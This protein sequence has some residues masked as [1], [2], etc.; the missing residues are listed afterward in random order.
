[1]STK[2]ILGISIFGVL[3]IAIAIGLML[4]SS[5]L[6]RDI[7]SVQLPETPVSSGS[8]ATSQPDA[9]DRVEVTKETVQAVISTLRRPATYSRNVTIES[10]W[11]SDGQAEYVIGVFVRDGSTS[12]RI[13]PPVGPLKR[14]IVTT[15]SLY[16]WYSDDLAPFIGD[17]GSLGDGI[18]NADEW[19]MLASYEDV[20]A[21]NKEFITDAGYIEYDGADSIFIEYRSPLLG[22]SV[23]Y[24]ISVELGLVTAAEEYDTDGTLVYRMTADECM[25]GYIDPAEFVLPDGTE[26]MDD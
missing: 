17:T 10:Y 16:I 18:T 24:Y 26:L 19:Q 23:I 6:G 4:L 14:T 2:R 13:N 21:L 22:Y 3:F 5:Y 9:L 15:D 7:G 1:M 12:L 11:E 20:L 25:L 8:P